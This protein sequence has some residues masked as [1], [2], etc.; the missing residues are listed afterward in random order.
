MQANKRKA[1]DDY[2]FEAKKSDV[3]SNQAYRSWMNY[4]M[5]TLISSFNSYVDYAGKHSQRFVYTD[6]FSPSFEFKSKSVKTSIKVIP[7]KDKPR[8]PFSLVPQSQPISPNTFQALNHHVDFI[9][10][11]VVGNKLFIIILK[12]VQKDIKYTK[13]HPERLEKGYFNHA[14]KD[15]KTPKSIYQQLL[16][17]MQFIPAG[18]RQSLTEQTGVMMEILKEMDEL[19]QELSVYIDNKNYIK[20]KLKRGEEILQRLAIIL[21]IL[22]QKK[23]ILYQDIEQIYRTYP[24]DQNSRWYVS[25]EALLKNVNINKKIL[26]T[27]KAYCKGDS[28]SIPTTETLDALNKQIRKVIIDQYDNMQGIKKLGRNH[29]RCPYTPYEDIPKDSKVFMKYAKEL[30]NKPAKPKTYEDFIYLY[31]NF[32]KDYNKFASLSETPVLKNIKQPDIFL[33]E[34]DQI[35]TNNSKAVTEEIDEEFMK[36][37]DGYATNNIVLLLDVSS[38]MHTREKLP[39]LKKSL[40]YLLGIMRPEDEISLVVYSGKAEVL[41]KGISSQEKDKIHKVIDNLQSGGNTN[42]EAGIKLAYKTAD[43]NYIRGGNNRI[44]MATDGEFQVK[45]DIYQLVE[46]YAKEDISLSVFSFGKDDKVYKNL[47]QLSTQGKG[48]YEHINEKNADYKLVKEAKAKK[49]D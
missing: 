40:K 31:N 35:P 7:F 10:E 45:D 6:K 9:N 15:F 49:A 37:M 39:L 13:E 46:K 30:S 33:I 47:K 38:S 27:T 43:K 1:L 21:D 32:I 14:Y 26:F 41:L 20:D 3:F 8:I 44:I 29:G 12:K 11:A 22:D 28:T 34:P 36:N 5:G 24:T 42:S 17:E 23:E 4:Y 16:D 48:N 2:N 19:N 18:Y 25:S